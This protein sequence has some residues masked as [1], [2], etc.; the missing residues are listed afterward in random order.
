MARKTLPSSAEY[1]K[2]AKSFAYVAQAILDGLNGKRFSWGVG[3]WQAYKHK[4]YLMGFTLTSKTA[5][6][7]IGYTL[8]KNAKPIGIAAMGKS[9]YIGH[10]YILQCHFVP[11]AAPQQTLAAELL[12]S[13]DNQ[14]SADQSQP[15]EA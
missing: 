3:E 1:L 8:K 11:P 4:A 5:A 13:S 7:E 12:S 2:K 15:A 10:V 9:R 6:G 14:D